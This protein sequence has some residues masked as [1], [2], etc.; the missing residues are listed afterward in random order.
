MG[1]MHLSYSFISFGV[2]IYYSC[3]NTRFFISTGSDAIEMLHE[4]FQEIKLNNKNNN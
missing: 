4:H 3:I 2:N 1:Y